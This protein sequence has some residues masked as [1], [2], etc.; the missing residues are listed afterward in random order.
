MS[1]DVL[2][3]LSVVKARLAVN[4][5]TVYRYIRQGK[6]KAVRVGGLWRVRESELER[7]LQGGQE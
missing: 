2:L 1:E 5:E 7:F 4:I 3:K 6:L